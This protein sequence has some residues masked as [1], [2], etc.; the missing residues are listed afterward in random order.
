M[1]QVYTR[2]TSASDFFVQVHPLDQKSTKFTKVFPLLIIAMGE[3]AS[4]CFD[5]ELPKSKIEKFLKFS[6]S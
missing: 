6:K 4:R 3:L 2:P 5:G 1:W